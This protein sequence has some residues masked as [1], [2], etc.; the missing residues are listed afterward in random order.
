MKNITVEQLA[1]LAAPQLIDVREPDEFAAAHAVGAI[2]VPLGG[3]ESAPLPDESA[4]VYVICQSGGRSLRGVQTL[5]ARGLDA[6]NVEGGT[7]AWIHAGH[8]AEAGR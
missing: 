5:A 1:A 6:V 8:P 2:N 7:S 4:T 3:L